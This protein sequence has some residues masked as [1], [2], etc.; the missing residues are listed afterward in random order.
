MLYTEFKEIQ[1]KELNEFTSKYCF[2]AFSRDQLSKKLQ[3][4][5]ITEEE[6]QKKYISFYGG[7]IRADKVAEYK[8]L[9][10]KHRRQLSENMKNS[11]FA[12]SA[13]LY[14]LNNHEYGYTYNGI[15]AVEALNL[16]IHEVADNL[17][18]NRAYRKACEEIKKTSEY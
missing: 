4:L 14:E 3:E 17:T 5:G 10:D 18:L 11:D 2:W 15:P 16:T 6:M 1:A 8:K 7:A 13:F 9:A 12:Y